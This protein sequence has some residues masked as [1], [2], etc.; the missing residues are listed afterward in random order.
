[1]EYCGVMPGVLLSNAWSIM[2][3]CMEYCGGNACS[4]VGV[5]LRVIWSNT[6]TK[7]Q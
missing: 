5:M 2:G 6:L 1:M 4:I 7:M 3:L